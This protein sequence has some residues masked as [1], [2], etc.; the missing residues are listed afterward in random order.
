MKLPEYRKDYYDCSSK[1]SDLTRQL[2]FAGIA[3]VWI[4]AIGKDS[5]KKL[6]VDLVWPCIFLVATLAAD[7]LQYVSASAVWGFYYRYLERKGHKDDEDLAWHSEKLTWPQ[8]SFFCL[9]LIL[10][11]VAYGF[12]LKAL[13]HRLV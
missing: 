9:K 6:A 8:L 11:A 13:F 1:A 4:F 12:L 7:F 2:A 5:D 10:V 3:V